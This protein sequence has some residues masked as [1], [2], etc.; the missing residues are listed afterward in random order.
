M[1]PHDLYGLPLERFVPERS[2]LAKA[3]RSEGR[4]SEAA[5]VAKLPKPSRAAWAVN[6]LVRTQRR[7]VSSLFEAGDAL[8]RAQE[9]VIAGRGDAHALRDAAERERAAVKRLTDAARGL[10]SADGH[11]LT[12]ATVDRVSETLHAAALDDGARAQVK[13]GCLDRELRHVGLGGFGA[14]SVAAPAPAP[15]GRR[16]RGSTVAPTETEDP[17][18]AAAERAA[19]Q[20]AAQERAAQ[21]R[22]ERLKAAR[23]AEVESRRAAE[24]A[25]RDFQTAQGRRDRAAAALSGAED[26]VKAA[27]REAERAARAYE[28]ARAELERL[29]P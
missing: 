3:L 17:G 21:Q 29:Q 19:Q 13:E 1:D 15:R 8:Q 26:A 7:A 18:A 11:A 6:Q 9:D 5:E 10:L 24:R 2:D 27:R 20:R 22:A 16:P 25:E 4:R 14:M 28:R 23:Q 12:P